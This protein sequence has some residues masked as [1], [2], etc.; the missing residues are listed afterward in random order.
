VDALSGLVNLPIPP[1]EVWFEQVPRGTPGGI[2]P[3]DYVLVAVMKFDAT[4]TER[5]VKGA[6][7]RP[8]S[9]PRISSNANRP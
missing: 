5:L 6:S 4:S 3:T 1:S 8:G 7:A 9:P 2:G